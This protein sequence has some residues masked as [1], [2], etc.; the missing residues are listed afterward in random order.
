MS[1][2]SHKSKEDNFK[3]L[4]MWK[5][6]EHINQMKMKEIVIWGQKD[7]SE[8]VKET[9]KQLNL[10]SYILVYFEAKD[11]REEVNYPVF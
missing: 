3:E 2:L 9:L 6:K 8:I 4:C 11:W 10:K 1:W 7:C 5:L